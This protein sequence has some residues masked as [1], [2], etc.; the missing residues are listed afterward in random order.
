MVLQVGHWRL[1]GEKLNDY[2][3][4]FK[5][6]EENEDDVLSVSNLP[7]VLVTIIIHGHQT[8]EMVLVSA[9]R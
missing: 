8:L 1:R 7:A 6:C 5:T 9:L 2:R 3:D 4:D